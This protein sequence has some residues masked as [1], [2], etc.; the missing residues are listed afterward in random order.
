MT[1]KM[2]CAMR[3]ENVEFLEKMRNETPFAC[4][5]TDKGDSP[6]HLAASWGQL[7]QVKNIL[8]EWPSLLLESNSMDQLPL[9]A[10]ASAGR[11][12]VVEA[13]INALT[14]V[15]VG[16]SE[17]EIRDLYAIKDKNGDTT[18]HLALKGYHR[19]D[20]TCLVNANPLSSLLANIE[21]VSPLYMAAKAGDLALVKKMMN[22]LD[23]MS[24]LTS[25]L[26]GRKSIIHAA[27]WGENSEMIDVILHKDPNLVNERDENGRTCLSFGALIGF[28]I[29][30]NN[31]LNR[32]TSSVFECDD[33]GSF[34]IHNA[35]KN[36]HIF[37]ARNIINRCP[38][39]K[40]LLNK[41]GQNILHIAASSGKC[42]PLFLSYIRTLDRNNNMREAQDINGNTPLHLATLKW[43]PRTVSHLNIPNSEKVLNMPNNDGLRAID[44][45]EFNLQ[46]KYVF[47]ER[48]TMMVLLCACPRGGL[49][50]IPT[51]GM[52]LKS[53]SEPQDGGKYK[54]NVNILLLV[55]TLVAT[56]AFAAGITIPGGFSSSPPNLGMAVLANNGILSCFLIFDTVAMQCSVIAIVALIWAQLGDPELAHKAFHVALPSLFAAL[57]SM[58][59]AFLC[60]VMA[61]T[62]HNALLRDTIAIIASTFL[63][64]TAF[65]L[66]PYAIPLVFGIRIFKFF[67]TTY[68]NFLVWFVNDDDADI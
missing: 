2:Y 26:E 6:L 60:G 15:S 4:F 18:L 21:G 58:S 68:L 53:K 39:S 13:L 25:K 16:P 65:L 44:I 49:K 32:S 37:L 22:S 46:S 45:A 24:H 7:D 63:L 31:L 54:D 34:P 8:S 62:W 41:Q 17:A 47:R 12:D 48:I 43:R 9:H 40:Y 61:T 5:K 20:A 59:S 35:V 27:L 30:V 3:A 42:G 66:S 11:E 23:Q 29:G 55:A 28:N 52:T 14:A 51:S 57:F 64:I 56:V 19:M 1:R 50:M 67:T 33:D 38:E 36:G 10:A